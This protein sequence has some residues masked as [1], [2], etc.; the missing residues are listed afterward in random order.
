VRSRYAAVRQS[1]SNSRTRRLGQKASK[2]MHV[3][4]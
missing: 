1:S 2:T 4:V 3:T